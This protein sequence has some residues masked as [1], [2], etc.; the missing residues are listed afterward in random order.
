MIGL[1]TVGTE[2]PPAAVPF[3]N[4][5]ANDSVFIHVINPTTN[6]WTKYTGGITT[7][8]AVTNELRVGSDFGGRFFTGNIDEVR[9]WNTPLTD[10]NF[11][12]TYNS[13]L[14]A[15]SPNSANLVAYYNF[16]SVSGTTVADLS[17]NGNTGSLI[18]GATGVGPDAL[19]G[20]SAITY[21][22]TPGATLS[23]TNTA[24]TIEIGRASCRERV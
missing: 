13:P 21:S 4:N 6:T 7:I 8:A 18:G 14:T 22:W 20:G 15:S 16:N 24:S 10:A 5:G 1:P 3:K 9:I 23:S 17:G 11:I 19:I 2:I 12:S